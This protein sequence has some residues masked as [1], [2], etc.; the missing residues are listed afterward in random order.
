MRARF[1]D[2]KVDAFLNLTPTGSTSSIQ[3]VLLPDSLFDAQKTLGSHIEVDDITS[4]AHA[5]KLTSACARLERKGEDVAE[6]LRLKYSPRQM[7]Y[8]LARLLKRRNENPLADAMTG[9]L[10]T[11]ELSD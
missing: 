7:K 5:V 8:T 1:G 9:V 6:R 11:N 3:K 10:D 4:N 2:A